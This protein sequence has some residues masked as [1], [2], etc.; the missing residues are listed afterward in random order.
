MF[1]NKKTEVTVASSSS[2]SPIANSNNSVVVGTKIEGSIFA[3]SDIRI[4]GE[5]K[6]T[7]ECSGKVIIGPD[8]MVTGDINC[9]NAVIEGSFDGK[10]ICQDLLNVRE[11]AKINGDIFTDKLIVQAGA[12]YNVN[13][14]MG[15]VQNTKSIAN[16]LSSNG[17]SLKEIVLEQ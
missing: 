6:G 7:L 13:C 5:L 12:V 16:G 11:S 14:Q 2:S 17:K 4:D 1:G 8:G 9:Q 10:L 3:G 15:R